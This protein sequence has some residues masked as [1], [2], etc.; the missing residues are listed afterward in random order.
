M[1]IIRIT[2]NLVVV[3]CIVF[4]GQFRA[5]CTTQLKVF[6]RNYTVDDGLPQNS[7]NDLLQDKDGYIWVATTGGIRRTDGVKFYELPG[8]KEGRISNIRNASLRLDKS[9]NVWVLSNYLWAVYTYNEHRFR[10]VKEFA[11]SD[12]SNQVVMGIASSSGKLLIHRQKDG[13]S[14]IETTTQTI[15]NR[16]MK[17]FAFTKGNYEFQEINQPDGNLFVYKHAGRYYVADLRSYTER[18]LP[19]PRLDMPARDSGKKSFLTEDNRMALRV[20]AASGISSYPDLL[21]IHHPEFV[22]T[23]TCTILYNNLADREGIIWRYP[24]IQNLTPDKVWYKYIFDKWGNV[25]VASLNTGLICFNTRDNP[26]SI[27]GREHQN[28]FIKGITPD[29]MRK[30]TIVTTYNEGFYVLNTDKTIA[31]DYRS[32]TNGSLLRG[33]NIINVLIADSTT[34]VF[35]TQNAPYTYT[36]DLRKKTIA[37]LNVFQLSKGED[38]THYCSA[39]QIG[40]FKYLVNSRH[41]IYE[42]KKEGNKVVAR[43]IHRTANKQLGCVSVIGN[44]IYAGY[45]G[46]ISTLSLSGQVQKVDTLADNAELLVKDVCAMPSG[47]LYV[48]TTHGLYL[49]EKNKLPTRIKGLPE[50]YIYNI[51]LTGEGTLWMT[52]NKGMMLY[53]PLTGKASLYSSADGF[54]SNEC[55]SNC[56]LELPDG[57]MLAGTLQG[58]ACFDPRNILNKPPPASPTITGIFT[59]GPGNRQDTLIATESSIHLPYDR[60]AVTVTFADL[61][62]TVREHLV[63][64]YKKGVPDTA[65]E[66]VK[67]DNKISLSLPTGTHAIQLQAGDLKTGRFSTSTALNIIVAPPFW[68]TWWFYILEVLALLTVAYTISH[69]I[70]R[71][72]MQKV[73]QQ[74]QLRTALQ[75]ERERI[76]REL[77]D[78]LGAQATTLSAGLKELEQFLT[79]EAGREV[80]THVSETGKSIMQQLRESIWALNNEQIPTSNLCDRFKVFAKGVL[81]NFPSIRFTLVEDLPD[82]PELNPA[83]ALNILRILQEA[84]HNTVKHANASEVSIHVSTTGGLLITYTDNGSGFTEDLNTPTDSYGLTNMK[85]RAEAAGVTLSIENGKPKGMILTISGEIK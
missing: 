44:H 59:T 63:F 75:S 4:V 42:I 41:T 29:P 12:Q 32:F 71:R 67:D 19:V 47:D 66:Y 22:I 18:E 49:L 72:R 16:G 5:F 24:D 83:A 74:L 51:R 70:H 1:N 3:L 11:T 50:N 54:P 43:Q 40:N 46:G 79:R 36:A 55:N 69:L 14:E 78:N 82:D 80:L 60:H 23:D 26:F 45:V 2:G 64:R 31:Y 13:L 37:P 9:G 10:I 81:R 34:Y 58:L 85:K 76:S 48:A 20:L 28:T 17:E 6:V 56:L 38:F 30:Q 73:M 7:L 77:H 68:Q 84:L 53:Q 39:A 8:D 35:L 65:W 25:W 57:K 21:H 52:T 61:S 33:H 27:I 15:T 62:Y